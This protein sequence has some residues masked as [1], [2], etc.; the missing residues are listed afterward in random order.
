MMAQYQSLDLASLCM[1]PPTQCYYTRY[2]SQRE[3]ASARKSRRSTA[4]EASERAVQHEK[5]RSWMNEPPTERNSDDEREALEVQ[6]DSQRAAR[7][8]STTP[9]QGSTPQRKFEEVI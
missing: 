9:V 5:R 4:E 1:K 3:M 7:R 8:R 6:G 2:S